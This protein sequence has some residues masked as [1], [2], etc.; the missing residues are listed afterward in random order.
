MGVAGADEYSGF[1]SNQIVICRPTLIEHLLYVRH[2]L[3]EPSMSNLSVLRLVWELARAYRPRG[4][5]IRTVARC[6]HLCDTASP[7]VVRRAPLRPHGRTLVAGHVSPLQMMNSLMSE[8]A[9]RLLS[10]VA[11]SR[12]YV[13][14]KQ[15]KNNFWLAHFPQTVVS[16]A[17]GQRVK[18][19]TPTPVPQREPPECLLSAGHWRV[20]MHCPTASGRAQGHEGVSSLWWLGIKSEP[21]VLL[22][23]Q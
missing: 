7:G 10:P 16:P 8:A 14:G 15:L 9:P 20:A 19:S 5:S 1:R 18:V 4:A 12:G 6:C 21:L 3:I 23:S 11:L 13:H 17:S 22:F 2:F